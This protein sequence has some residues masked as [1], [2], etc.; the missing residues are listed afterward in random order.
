VP[1]PPPGQISDPSNQPTV[2]SAEPVIGTPPP[3]PRPQG[4]SSP[5][6]GYPVMSSELS[7]QIATGA[8]VFPSEPP[9]GGPPGAAMAPPMYPGYGMQP[10]GSGGYHMPAMPGGAMFDPARAADMMSPV[11]HHYPEHLDWNAV[12]ARPARAVPPW[13]LAT[14]FVGAIAIALLLTVIV[15]RLIH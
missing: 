5:P 1:A 14:L 2:I 8:S 4:G 15:A 13:L 11:G 12:A 6:V 3:P 9:H 7:A 10:P